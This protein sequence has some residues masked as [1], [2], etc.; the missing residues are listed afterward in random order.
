M[1]SNIFCCI[2][3]G[4]ATIA[5]FKEFLSL[6]SRLLYLSLLPVLIIL[7]FALTKIR[8]MLDFRTSTWLNLLNH[9]ERFMFI[10]YCIAGVKLAL[11]AI[12][13]YSAK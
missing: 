5:G 8:E 9:L 2:P 3:A 13:Y 12:K 7:E 4:I 10:Y 1:L 6:R 11:D